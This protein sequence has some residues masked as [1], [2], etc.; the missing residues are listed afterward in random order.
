MSEVITFIF[1]LIKSTMN[2]LLKNPLIVLIIIIGLICS[3]FEKRILGWF[4][5]HWTK[6][7]LKKLPKDKYIIINNV[8]IFTN[9][10]T[11]QIDHVIVSPYGIFSIETKQYNGYIVGSKYDKNWVRYIGK[12]KIYYTNPIRQNY[13]HVKSLSELLKIEESKIYNI[14][15][16]PSRAKLKIQH[17]GELV[18][19][20]TIVNKILSY[21]DEIINNTGEIVETIN[22]NNIKDKNL[23]N[24]HNKNIKENII[25]KDSNKCPKCGGILVERNGKYGQF[26]G[27]SNYPKCRYTR[28]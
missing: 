21:K 24:Q 10:N 15:C 9:G 8:F 23:L 28:K 5:E 14:V 22:K 12:K 26:I 27:C 20:D 11:H 13:G 1:E 3:I 16:I 2:N 18:R 4:G 17:D 25:D 19:Y 7:A 6:K